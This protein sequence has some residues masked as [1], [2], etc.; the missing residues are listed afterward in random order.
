ML[1]YFLLLLWIVALFLLR[2]VKIS[3]FLFVVGSVGLFCFLMHFGRLTI[4]R[5]M[6][7]AVTLAMQF[8]GRITG[9]FTA[10]PEYSMITL[11]YRNEAVTFF[12][13]Y[14][15]SGF[16]ETIVYISLVLFYP[17]HSIWKRFIYS[18]AGIIYIF[19][20]NAVRVFVICSAVKLFGNRMFFLSHTILA[21]ILFFFLMV[22]LYYTVFTKPHIFKQKVGNLTYDS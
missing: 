9:F 6:E 11:Y 20:S 1:P 17:L 5:H 18:L 13:D 21:R 8:I 10:Y 15:C 4:E 14:E 16:I 12:V 7:F 3:F 2:N 19:L 22:A